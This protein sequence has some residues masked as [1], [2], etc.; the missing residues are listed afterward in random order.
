MSVA[1]T[2]PGEITQINIRIDDLKDYVGDQ[3]SGLERRVDNRFATLESKVDLINGTLTKLI[4]TEEHEE[5]QLGKKHNFRMALTS[6]ASALAV[7]CSVVVP[8]T[9]K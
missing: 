7:I 6:A 1:Y 4:A 3:V 8:L 5:K 9:V 2:S